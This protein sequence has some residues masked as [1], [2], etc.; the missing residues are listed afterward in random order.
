M[1]ACSSF[2][3]LLAALLGGDRDYG[4]D[5]GIVMGDES[6]EDIW[7]GNEVLEHNPPTGHGENVGLA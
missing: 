2:L 6:C 4:F 5:V 7:N 1:V 3:W